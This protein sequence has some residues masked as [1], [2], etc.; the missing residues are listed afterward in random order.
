MGTILLN[1]NH[2]LT[3]AREWW[4]HQRLKH[5][6][7][8][9]QAGLYEYVV[10]GGMLYD[11]DIHPPACSKLDTY[12]ARC[13]NTPYGLRG[14]PLCEVNANRVWELSNILH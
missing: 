8:R 4:Y 5:A 12:E 10:M 11:G 3:T 9:A 6:C 7:A 2:L 13:G 1:V 14:I